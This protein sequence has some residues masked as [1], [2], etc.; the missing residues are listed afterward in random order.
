MTNTTPLIQQTPYLT[1]LREIGRIASTEG[2]K[3][4]TIGGYVRDLFLSRET[5]DLDFVCIGENSG[6]VLAEAVS[7]GMGG[8]TAHVYP[9]FGTAAI[10]VPL[11]GARGEMLLKHTRF[12]L[13][14]EEQNNPETLG[15]V[16]EVILKKYLIDQSFPKKQGRSRDICPKTLWWPA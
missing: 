2:I 12:A 16:R 11:P 15:D 13:G 7:K 5:T 8:Q 10:R 1:L 4:Y 6:V 3:T 9:N 14:P